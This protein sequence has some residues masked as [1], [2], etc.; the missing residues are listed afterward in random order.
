[1][2]ADEG[3]PFDYVV[4]ERCL[5]CGNGHESEYSCTRSTTTNILIVK[6]R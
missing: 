5:E 3:A 1:M 6:I 4:K 2:R